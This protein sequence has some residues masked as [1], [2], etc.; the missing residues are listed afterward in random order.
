MEIVIYLQI[1]KINL[2]ILSEIL[3][4]GLDTI[5][6]KYEKQKMHRLKDKRLI[7]SSK[8][9][10]LPIRERCTMIKKRHIEHLK[11]G[12]LGSTVF[13]SSMIA[14]LGPCVYTAPTTSMCPALCVD[15]VNT[16]PSRPPD[17]VF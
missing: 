17:F 16:F 1:V 7:I 8:R 2:F 4:S 11:L 3:V 6:I 14:L 13:Q 9:S 5:N 15:K 10:R 12:I